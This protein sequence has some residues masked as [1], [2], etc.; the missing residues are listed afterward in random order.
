MYKIQH[1]TIRKYRFFHKPLMI[2]KLRNK[3]QKILN[4][5]HQR[6]HSQPRNY[7]KLQQQKYKICTY[8]AAN[9]HNSKYLRSK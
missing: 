9:A 1:M 6:P 3:S 8:L 5:G 2:I 7:V 4:N